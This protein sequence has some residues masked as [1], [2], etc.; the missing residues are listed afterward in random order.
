MRIDRNRIYSHL[1]RYKTDRL[2]ITENGCWRKKPYPPILPEQEYPK[3]II[4]KGYHS[5]ILETAEETGIKLHHGF[6]H[7]NSSQALA[8]NLFAPLM[9]E[10]RIETV[11]HVL[12]AADRAEWSQFEYVADRS[13]GT[14]FDFFIK[15]ERRNYYFEIKYTE[16]GFGSAGM[17][18]EHLR[19]F[20]ILYKART[21]QTCSVGV[22]EFFQKYQLWRNIC[23]SSA[24]AVVFVFPAFQKD[25]EREILLAKEKVLHPENIM[26]MHID[27]LVAANL[28]TENEKLNAHYREFELKYLQIQGIF[29]QDE[30]RCS[31]GIAMNRISEKDW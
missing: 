13:E 21:A 29:Q 26:V 9:K 1:A 18:A 15:G 22:E 2:G 6:H 19:K 3:N 8:F 30:W 24:G 20:E 23:Y 28:H 31:C 4:D 14:N 27:D 10:N 5:W 12:R 16:G 25:L 17:D 11:F 7:L